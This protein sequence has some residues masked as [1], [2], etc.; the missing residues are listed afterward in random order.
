M[1]RRGV[2]ADGHSE[3]GSG[4]GTL[5]F[6][7]GTTV[8]LDSFGMRQFV[9]AFADARRWVVVGTEIEYE[10]DDLGCMVGFSWVDG[11]AA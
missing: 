3:Q 8:Y 10:T 11:E 6:E 2:I 9:D 5:T 4:I 7:D 1:K